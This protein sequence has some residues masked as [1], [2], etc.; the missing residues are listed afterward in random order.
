[1]FAKTTKNVTINGKTEEVLDELWPEGEEIIN[2]CGSFA[3]SLF[4]CVS[5]MI[6]V[7]FIFLNLFIAIILDSFDT[8]KDEES[9]QIGGDTLSKFN[10]LWAGDQFDPKGTKLININSFN[11]FLLAIIDEEI[12]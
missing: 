9:L 10:D 1:M 11:K 7:S 5:F 8:S 12:R 2:G 3:A 4:F 6:V